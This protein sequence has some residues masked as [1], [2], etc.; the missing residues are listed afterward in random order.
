MPD[1]GATVAVSASRARAA[2]L[3][4]LLL[5]AIT[6]VLD[7][8]LARVDEGLAVASVARGH[9]AVEH[10]D[11]GCDGLQQILRSTHPHQVARPLGWQ[12]WGDLAQ[13]AVQDRKSTRLNSSHSQIS[14]AV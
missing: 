6:R 14:Y 1:V 13:R 10:V 2:L 5:L 11:A 4:R 9:H 8:D 12:A 7:H 3:Q